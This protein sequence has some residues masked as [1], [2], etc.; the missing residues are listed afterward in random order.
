MNPQYLYLFPLCF[1]FKLVS[2]DKEVRRLDHF[3]VITP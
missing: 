2:F 1:K 3:S